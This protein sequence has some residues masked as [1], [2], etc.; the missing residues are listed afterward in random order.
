MA[1]ILSTSQA[2]D[3]DIG[4]SQAE[5]DWLAANNEILVAIDPDAQPFEYI[6]N[7]RIDGIAGDYLNILSEKLGV[8]FT[9]SGNENW[10]EA[11]NMIRSGQV[12]I[13]PTTTA[14]NERRQYLDFVPLYHTVGSTIFV[15]SGEQRFSSLDNLRGEKIAQITGFAETEMIA[16]AYPDIEIIEVENIFEAFQMLSNGD[17]SAHIGNMMIG[18][19]IMKQEG[20]DNIIVG[21]D[22]PFQGTSNIAVRNDIPLFTSALEKAVGS[23][24]QEQHDA[25]AEKWLSINLEG[26]IDYGLIWRI[27]LFACI[28]LAL[29]LIWVMIL[30][31]EVRRRK[32][33]ELQAE[34]ANI[35]KSN[36]IA[37]LSHEIRTPLNAI[38]GFSDIMSEGIF[39][40]IK[41]PKYKDYLKNIKTSGRHLE[42]VINDILDLSKIEADKWTLTEEEFDLIKCIKD[43]IHMLD[44][45]AIKRNIR[46]SV[47]LIDISEPFMIIA[48]A[49][50]IRRIIINLF[51]N[52]I[53]FT[54]EGGR[55]TCIV[56]RTEYGDI[57]FAVKDTGVGISPSKLC[58]VLEPFGQAHTQSLTKD[59]GTGL[60]LPIVKKLTELHGGI[61]K[62]ESEVDVGTIV[63]I[64]L[65]K[66]RVVV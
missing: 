24:S 59:A 1:F 32:Q 54:E 49:A 47:E 23:I 58:H 12:H 9:W 41:E 28:L 29:T 64:T 50:S 65:P 37:N 55:I 2:A 45:K 56:S 31:R 40:E 46:M 7:G 10:D 11:M 42:V 39:G 52:A 26:E 44:S 57:K 30:R 60:G 48:E 34:R 25:I 13:L 20:I 8:N 63:T 53:K 19:E 43:A 18:L 22:S 15:K 38:I 21:G 14:T 35:A 3:N 36:F 66:E 61:I 62:L 51:S 33:A 5:K 16:N 17:V 27:V 6:T 4:L